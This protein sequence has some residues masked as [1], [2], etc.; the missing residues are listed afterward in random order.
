MERLPITFYPFEVLVN[1]S[2]RQ[3]LFRQPFFRHREEALRRRDLVP[4]F[5]S[6][7]AL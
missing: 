7:L 1:F 5:A 3:P 2:G 6:V 4:G